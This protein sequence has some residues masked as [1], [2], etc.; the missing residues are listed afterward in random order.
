M[1][2]GE[3]ISKTYSRMG[4]RCGNPKHDSYKCYGGKGIK[5]LMSKEDLLFLWKRDKADKLLNPSIDRINSNG[6]YEVSNCRFIEL[7]ANRLRR[8]TKLSK[9]QVYEIKY[10]KYFFGL[11][12]LL[13]NKFN[14]S[15]QTISHIRRGRYWKYV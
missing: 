9:E 11:N 10:A 13:A 4:Q 12:N 7:E 14:V 3:R 6:H 2:V 15:I 8:P 5:V 1:K